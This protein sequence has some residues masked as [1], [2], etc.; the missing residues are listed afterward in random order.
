M[1]MS[2]GVRSEGNG[3]RGQLQLD[4]SQ[5]E[6]MVR[7]DGGGGGGGG[8]SGGLCRVLTVC[9]HHCMSVWKIELSVF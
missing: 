1:G 5:E 9:H 2:S 8:G 6:M 3:V 4:N 7:K